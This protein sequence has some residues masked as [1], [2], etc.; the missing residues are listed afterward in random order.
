MGGVVAGSL[1]LVIASVATRA[2]ACSEGESECEQQ[3]QSETAKGDA[4]HGESLDERGW[5]RRRSCAG[6]HRWQTR[7][8]DF[9]DLADARYSQ[10]T[11]H[12]SLACQLRAAPPLQRTNTPQLRI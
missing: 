12:R 6:L 4:I 8:S 9:V 5:G 3:D 1:R 11:F 2:M 10:G 7:R